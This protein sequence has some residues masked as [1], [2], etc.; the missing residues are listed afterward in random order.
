MSTRETAVSGQFYPSNANEITATLKKYNEILDTYFTTHEDVAKLK[1]KAVIVPHAG[2]IYSGFTANV[3]LRLLHNSGIKQIVVIGPSHR[4]SLKGTSV[5]MYDSYATP[6]GHLTID[7]DLSHTLKEKFALTFVPDAHH[8]HSTEVQM[9][10]IKNYDPDVSVVELVY[11]DEDPQNLAHVIEYL[12]GQA[13][14]GVVISSDLSHFYDIDKANRLDTICMNAVVKQDEKMLHQGC[15]ACGKIGI[16][17]MITASKKRALTPKV[18]DYRTSADTSGDKSSVVGYM[19]VAFVDARADKTDTDRKSEVLLKLARASIAQ[20]VGVEYDL[21]LDKTLQENSWL[22]EDGATFVTL[23]SQNEQLRGCIGSLVSHR[24]LYKDVIENAKSAA[25]KD[26]RFIPLKKEEFDDITVEVS[27]LT[28]SRPVSYSTIDELRSKIKIGEDGVI[29][30]HGGYKA[31]FLPQVWEQLPSFDIF[32]SHLCKKA[33]MSDRCLDQK[34][35][36]SIYQ[37]QK[38]IENK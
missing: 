33:G 11:G 4:V 1:P 10:M 27:I 35:D 18:L 30:T 38:Y 37:V 2:Y 34:P 23:T 13:H 5:S 29:L 24:D 26:P 31:T 36:I 9:P 12:L 16:E 6:L 17:A 20:A 14:V 22:K 32:F 21:D 8:E 19:S 15:E 7:K 3:A 25:I 28:P